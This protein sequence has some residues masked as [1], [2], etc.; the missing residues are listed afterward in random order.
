MLTPGM[1]SPLVFS[2]IFPLKCAL[3]VLG[4]SIEN[5]ALIAK[6]HIKIRINI[7]IFMCLYCCSEIDIQSGFRNVFANF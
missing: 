1:G 5:P 7:L 2:V 4:I 6:K 3:F